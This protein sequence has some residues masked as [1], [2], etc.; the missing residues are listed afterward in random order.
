MRQGTPMGSF[1]QQR[2]RSED[3]RPKRSQDATFGRVA[4]D[5]LDRSAV[6]FAKAKEVRSIIET[7]P[8]GAMAGSAK[9]NMSC[10]RCLAG[11]P[12]HRCPQLLRLRP[13]TPL[14]ICATFF[15]GLIGARVV[16][17]RVLTKSKL[18]AVWSDAGAMGYP[19]R[20]FSSC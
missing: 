5:F 3:R 18:R 1:D 2:D 10:R 4:S 15:G 14:Q 8:D 9:S 12:A 7:E 13:A 20:A 16:G 17:Q 6:K 19:T 11:D